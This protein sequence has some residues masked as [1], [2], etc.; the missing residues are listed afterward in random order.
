MYKNVNNVTFV[1][2]D[3]LCDILVHQGTGDI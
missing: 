2:V 1:C 3:G